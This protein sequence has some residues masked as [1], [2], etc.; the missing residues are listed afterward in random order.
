VPISGR[1]LGSIKLSEEAKEL[2]GEVKHYNPIIPTSR[3]RWLNRIVIP[4]QEQL[5][6]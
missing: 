6:M 5:L 3:N 1:N 4:F 2:P